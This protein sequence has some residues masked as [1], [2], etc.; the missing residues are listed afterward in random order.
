MLNGLYDALIFFINLF[1]GEYG[2][3]YLLNFALI[4]IFA[5]FIDI[6]L[7]FVLKKES[8]G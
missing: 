7:S 1:T 4:V 8:L 6:V 3:H 5:A 2:S